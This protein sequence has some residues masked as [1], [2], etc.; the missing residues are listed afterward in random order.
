[1]WILAEVSDYVNIVWVLH[2]IFQIFIFW[3]DML[4]FDVFTA[5]PSTKCF[6]DHSHIT[7]LGNL[8]HR[9]KRVMTMMLMMMIMVMNC[10]ADHAG[11][12]TTELEAG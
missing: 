7:L 10:A 8:L 5:E 11:T 1:M 9:R 4:N 6:S 3:P 12:K 2:P